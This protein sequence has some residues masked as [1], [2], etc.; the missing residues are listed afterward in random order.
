MHVLVVEDDELS[1]GLLVRTINRCAGFTSHTAMNGKAA[2]DSI[3]ESSKQFDLILLD[4]SLPDVDGLEFIRLLSETT[5]KGSVIIASGHNMA[6][7]NSAKQLADV[8]HITVSG[9]LQKPIS[10]GEL[11]KLLESA[12]AKAAK[13]SPIDDTLDNDIPDSTII[14]YYQPQVDI[15]S[16]KVVRFEAISRLRL[17]DGLILGPRVALSRLRNTQDRVV[18]SRNFSEHVIKDFKKTVDELPEFPGVSINFDACVVEDYDF[19]A[20]LIA[21]VKNAGLP[22]WLITMEI[23]ERTLPPSKARLLES[24]TRLSMAGFRLS[25][26]DYGA[27]G[28]NQDLLRRSP[29]DEVKLDFGLIHS[30]LNDGPVENYVGSVVETARELELRIVGK[31]IETEEHLA[32]ARQQ[33]IE[34]AQGFV[35]DKPLP[36]ENAVDVLMAE[37]DVRKTA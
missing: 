4:L 33:G 26:D 36:I 2:I 29:F 16:G 21:M 7:L 37:P 1:A 27:G 34:I 15:R 9:I 30:E 14:P 19:M 20:S 12:P 5:F 23:N 13:S 31:N 6:V 35:F 17:G 10:P 18:A 11:R 28:S 32:F 22:P 24:L 8:H 25:L 3:E